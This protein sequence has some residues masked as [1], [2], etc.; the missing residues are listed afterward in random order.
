MKTLPHD[1]SRC[2]GVIRFNSAVGDEP[3]AH[4]T[5]P[6]RDTCQRYQ[7]WRHWDKEAGVP[8]YRGISVSMAVED[9]RHKIEEQ[10]S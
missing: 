7:A 8:D 10:S 1:V 2:S 6:E 5:C 3:P 4:D 9:C